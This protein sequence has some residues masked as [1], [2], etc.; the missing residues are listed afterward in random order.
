[1]RTGNRG[2]L[3]PRRS[4]E[5]DDATGGGYPQPYLWPGRRDRRVVVQEQPLLPKVHVHDRAVSPVVEE[6]LAVG[7]DGFDLAAVE[8]PGLLGEA[9][10]G[11]TRI[12]RP[13]QIGQVCA[14]VVMDK[15]PFR[16]VPSISVPAGGQSDL[17]L[18]AAR[19][20]G[21]PPGIS[22]QTFLPSPSFRRSA[23][24]LDDRRLGKQRVEVLQVL[25]ALHLEGYGWSNHPAVLMWRGHTRALVAYGLAV[26]EEWSG[27][28]YA[29]ATRADI[30]EFALPLPALAEEDLPP[31]ELPPW[32]GWDKLHRSHRAALIRKNQATYAGMF[33][34]TPSDLPYAWPAPPA[35]PPPAEPFSAWV[36]RA[37]SRDVL[38]SFRVGAFVGVP[39]SFGSPQATK[40]Q[41]QQY[42]RFR[43]VVDRGDPLVVPAG[44]AVHRGCW[45][46]R[47]HSGRSPESRT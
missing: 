19:P 17:P 43:E 46:G 8:L 27:R 14:G 38:A 26:I 12:E 41:R 35:G 30:A 1:M 36:V 47:L 11:R 15:M 21:L 32:L 40:K 16:H 25:R 34:D 44:G 22:M 28:G 4:D 29:D 2:C 42:H 39:V 23:V 13:T 10:R 6:V 3:A 5:V 31:E 33:L 9:A 18:H 37:G 7:L 24:V 20:A 45:P